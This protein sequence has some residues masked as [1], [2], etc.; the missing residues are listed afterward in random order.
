MYGPS[1]FFG[2]FYFAWPVTSGGRVLE[3]FE[4]SVAVKLP[5]GI[6]T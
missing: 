6:P 2:Y 1:V 3:L 5:C 4:V